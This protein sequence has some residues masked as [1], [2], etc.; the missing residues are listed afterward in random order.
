MGQ[1]VEM[2]GKQQSSA[3]Q[4]YDERKN[5]LLS[6]PAVPVLQNKALDTGSNG[7]AD[8]RGSFKPAIL[9]P[10]PGNLKQV[11][12]AVFKP[13]GQGYI[14]EETGDSYHYQYQAKDRIFLYNDQFNV[15]IDFS[16]NL[17]EKHAVPSGDTPDEEHDRSGKPGRLSLDDQEDGMLYYPPD[18]LNDALKEAGISAHK[19]T[20]DLTTQIVLMPV[21]QG[22]LYYNNKITEFRYIPDQ[23]WISSIRL[24][25]KDRPETQFDNQESHTVSWTL[26][27]NGIMELAGQPLS[28]FLNYIQA[29]FADLEPF[30][31]SAEGKLLEETSTG[32]A[33]LQTMG[34]GALPLDIWQYQTSRLLICYLQAYQLSTAATY[35]RGRAVGHGESHARQRLEQDEKNIKDRSAPRS[36][37]EVAIDLGKL[38][39]V[40]FRVSALGVREYAYAIKHWAD[41]I[42]RVFPLLVEEYRNEVFDPIL[43]K[44]ISNSFKDELQIPRDELFTVGD[45]LEKYQYIMGGGVK[46]KGATVLR[47]V[48]FDELVLTRLNTNFI[49]NVSLEPVNNGELTE[50]QISDG[51]S[52]SDKVYTYNDLAIRHVMLSDQDR[53]KTKFI[54]DQKSH[55]VPWTLARNAIISFAGHPLENLL[56]HLRDKFAELHDE[57]TQFAEALEAVSSAAQ[58]VEEAGV[59]RLHIDEWQELVSELVRRFFIAYQAAESTTYVN[60]EEADRAL[61]HGEGSHMAVLRRNEYTIDSYHGT[62]DDEDRIIAAITSMFDAS[63]TTSLTKENIRSAYKGLFQKLNHTFPLIVSHYG[64]LAHKR[65]LTFA[66]GDG[67]TLGDVISDE[68]LDAGDFSRFVLE[69]PDEDPDTVFSE[70]SLVDENGMIREQHYPLFIEAYR[71]DLALSGAYLTE[72]EG[73]LMATHLGLNIGVVQNVPEGFEVIGNPG[74]GN[75]LIHA[76][77]QAGKLIREN[78]LV[79]GATRDEIMALRQVLAER[80]TEDAIIPLCIA[81]V[82]GRITGM[83]EPGLGPE[84][85]R[86]LMDRSVIAAASRFLEEGYA[87]RN[88]LQDQAPGGNDG[89]QESDTAV[90][91]GDGDL[92]ADFAIYHHG[93]HYELIWKKQ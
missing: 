43:N 25:D 17:L 66:I 15:A 47:P 59:R 87:D 29:S 61:G 38:L 20:T 71:Y 73:D 32:N 16:G 7:G 77:V 19:L 70:D 31:E 8:G 44:Q 36:S 79:E 33:I 78:T 86:L 93:A 39:D 56:Q 69:E 58:L 76:L 12:Q 84:I 89:D 1:K 9:D 91:Y 45:L 22:E 24:G 92:H 3:A 23:V 72:A 88:V 27:R 28:A 53:P 46:Q 42:G 37:A 52:L 4:A 14:D 26:I 60:P 18:H 6:M 2:A 48:R 41:M 30:L 80:M 13:L 49:A 65:M 62:L 10:P 54:K 67:F 83:P 35:K 57:V 68:D 11:I 34:S 75:C 21:Q 50:R 82:A 90:N 81:A 85:R 5:A 55:T 40:Q 51:V 74:G 63:I 64:D